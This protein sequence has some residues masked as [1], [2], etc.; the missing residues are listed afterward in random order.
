MSR[1]NS[2]LLLLFVLFSASESIAKEEKVVDEEFAEALLLRP[3][4]D[5]KVLSH[6]HFRSS[7]PPSRTHG[8]H[9]HIF[10]KSIY[11]LV[12]FLG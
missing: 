8:R 3:L 9:H 5:R 10:P 7:A 11:Q 4:P 12:N 2:C 1:L 6:F